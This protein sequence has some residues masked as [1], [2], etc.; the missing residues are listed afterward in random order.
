MLSQ[1]APVPSSTDIP[2]PRPPAP[3]A[4][5]AAAAAHAVARSWVWLKW[6]VAL[7]ML[8][9]LY[10]RNADS[11]QKI[12]ETPKNWTFAMLGFALIGGSSLVTFGR[13]YLLVRA[14]EFVF[15]L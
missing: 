5:R 10:Y 12:A 9:W 8:T 7:G 3:I 2:A 6:P 13:W 1:T 15:S 14:Q 4:S 11:V